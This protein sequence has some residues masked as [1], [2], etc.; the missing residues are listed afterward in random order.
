MPDVENTA[1]TINM[2]RERRGLLVAIDAGRVEVTAGS[3]NWVR[4]TNGFNQRVERKVR[5][6]IQAGYVNKPANGS[7]KFT[8][9]DAGKRVLAEHI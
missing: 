6:L 1:S 4:R 2:N 3:G 8:I 9:T 7:S 5:E